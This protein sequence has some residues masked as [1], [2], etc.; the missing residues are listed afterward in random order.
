[1]LLSPPSLVP[2][3]FWSETQS[4]TAPPPPSVA[5]SICQNLLV[6]FRTSANHSLLS[7]YTSRDTETGVHFSELGDI[8][9]TTLNIPGITTFMAAPEH[10]T[11]AKEQLKGWE[12]DDSEFSTSKSIKSPE[13][14]KGKG[15]VKAKLKPKIKI[16]PAL[17]PK[18]KAKALP[19]K[20]GPPPPVP[21]ST[22]PICPQA[23]CHTQEGR[24]THHPFLVH[25]IQ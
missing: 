10:L 18:A 23:C 12:D 6:L 8:V 5:D 14:T 15:K 2:P 3:P 25:C 22:R 4:S 16:T 19:S 13:L 9:S 20:P 1:M 24:D 21:H 17:A 7:R 11:S